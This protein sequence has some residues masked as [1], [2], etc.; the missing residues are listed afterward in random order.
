MYLT[1]KH[2]RL[3][4]SNLFFCRIL[5][6][7]RVEPCC[8]VDVSLASS[9]LWWVSLCLAAVLERAC[10]KLVCQSL[11]A[12]AAA[13]HLLRQMQSSLLDKASIMDVNYNT[14]LY[15][16]DTS[17]ACMRRQQQCGAY[18]HG[19]SQ[20]HTQRPHAHAACRKA[21]LPAGPRSSRCCPAMMTA[22]TSLHIP[23][24]CAS[25]EARGRHSPH[26][27]MAQTLIRLLS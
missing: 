18:L 10:G 23:R 4:R 13:A 7:T 25:G 3:S 22:G 2:A 1:C 17:S 20:Q 11:Y 21:A 12:T 6:E 16:L 5:V 15:I 26:L 19:R 27:S 14:L 8:D 9:R 24:S